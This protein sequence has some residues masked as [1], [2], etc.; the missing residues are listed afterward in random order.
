MSEKIT[1]SEL[2]EKL[3]AKTSQS[4]QSTND[5]IHELASIIESSLGTGE[6][7][8]IS[9][10]GKFELRWVD[11]RKGRNPQTGE[12]I[13]IPAQNKVVFKPYKALRNHVN[14]PFGNLESQVIGDDAPD[15][16]DTSDQT[17][18]PKQA[19]VLPF[20]GT[21]NAPLIDLDTQHE[22]ESSKSDSLNDLIF[23]RESPLISESPPNVERQAS[24]Q[25]VAEPDVN[26]VKPE[27][28]IEDEFS[29]VFEENLARQEELAREVQENGGF[30]W[31]YTA[32][33]VIVLL[34]IFLLVFWMNT[35]DNATQSDSANLVNGSNVT[36]VEEPAA[37]NQDLDETPSQQSG[38]NLNSDEPTPADESQTEPELA[39]RA[40][41]SDQ[42]TENQ[43]NY[44][45][46]QGDTLWEIAQ[47]RYD[48]P[49]IW[50][51]IYEA[52]KESLDNP[53]TLSVENQI[54]IP[55]IEDGNQ[56]TRSEREQVALGYLSVYQW[57]KNNR[58][59]NARY[60][61]WAAGSFSQD[62]LLNASDSVRQSDLAFA[63][64]QG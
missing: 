52:N 5:F 10:F 31:S 29:L 41:N 46:Q 64:Q 37:I 27:I 45:I 44:S 12:E 6:K 30:R 26:P 55:L 1:F 54:N 58:P 43:M 16:E 15:E 7:I 13:T 19:P 61:L 62:V 38:Q 49:Y 3:S 21:A 17:V 4:Q 63:T 40:N 24:V 32:A 57:I 50:P 35:D 8:S 9:G 33:A 14:K 11:E 34:A 59:D 22:A 2:V 25:V 51:V 18:S 48:N 20:G 28:S 39:T 42:T 56:L 53:N 23:E 60:F 47:S 36:Q